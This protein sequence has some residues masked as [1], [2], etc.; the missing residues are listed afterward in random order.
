MERKEGWAC[1]TAVNWDGLTS[2]SDVSQL[3]TSLCTSSMCKAVT[4]RCV[5]HCVCTALVSLPARFNIRRFRSAT[6]SWLAISE[7]TY[8]ATK[9]MSSA[10]IRQ[11]F[12]ISVVLRRL[13]GAALGDPVLVHLA[14]SSS[15]LFRLHSRFCYKPFLLQ[16][17]GRSPADSSD[18][19]GIGIIEV[20]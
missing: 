2:G 1:G 11:G 10:L 3:C 6:R 12:I 9:E 8:R 20:N 5:H 19:R 7:S 13:F 18:S 4:H 15:K 14:V 17:C 16:S